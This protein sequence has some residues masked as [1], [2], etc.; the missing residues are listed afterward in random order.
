MKKK[1]LI[2]TE[3]FS[4]PY[5]EGIKKTVLH[6]FTEL[7][8]KYEVK[9]FC[10]DGIESDH[11]KVLKMNR[12]FLNKNLISNINKNNFDLII[13]LPFSSSTFASYVR[14]FI[15]KL[16]SN[17]KKILFFCLQPKDISNKLNFFIKFIKPD[18]GLTPSIDLKKK[19]DE[20]CINNILIP[21][22]TNLEN[23]KLSVDKNTLRQKYK[24]PKDKYVVLHIGHL[25]SGRNLE[26]LL[27]IQ[28]QGYQV[29][30]VS[31]TSTPKDAREDSKLYEK[32]V[33]N[34]IIVIN[35]FIENINEIYDLSDIYVFPVLAKNS[36]IGMPL[37]VLE[38]R[39]RSL[40]VVSTN[41]GSLKFFLK[42]DFGSIEYSNPKNFIEKIKLIRNKDNHFKRTNVDKINKIFINTISEQLK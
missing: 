22:F 19:W 8:K 9:L 33:S 26:S 40:P 20:N 16:I 35:N 3:I 27:P 21:L 4:P 23:N 11:I 18:L 7:E 39:A 30:I 12:L 36:S 32:L 42:D 37:S 10:R 17:N 14:L 25:N 15:L 38:A 41:F 2:I 24:I 6:L 5:D 13:Y 28:S 34:G 31:S 29:V 1:I